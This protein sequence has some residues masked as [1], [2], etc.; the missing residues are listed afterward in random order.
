MSHVALASLLTTL[1]VRKEKNPEKVILLLEQEIDG[2]YALRFSA[3]DWA[4][5][6][7]VQGAIALFLGYFNSRARTNKGAQDKGNSGVRPVSV[8]VVPS[9]SPPSQG[10]PPPKGTNEYPPAYS[11]HTMEV[12]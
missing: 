2:E 9:P 7:F 10:G 4:K 3:D 6:G 5:F 1:L 11:S 12:P 8:S